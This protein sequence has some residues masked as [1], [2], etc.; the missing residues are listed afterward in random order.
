MKKMKVLLNFIRFPHI[1][2]VAFYR[3]VITQLSGNLHFPTPDTPMD[4][5]TDMVNYLEVCHCAAKE[6]NEATEKALKIANIMTDE[7]FTAIADYV[8]WAARGNEAKIISSGFEPTKRIIRALK[9]ELTAEA[10]PLPG[11]MHLAA[12]AI[13]K[14]GAYIWQ[15]AMHA[16]PLRENDWTTDAIT[17][18]SLHEVKGLTAGANY[19]FRVAAVTPEGTTNF[20]VPI[21]RIA[22]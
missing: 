17:T 11:S 3:N 9:P 20:T 1:K 21:M 10:G 7:I 12:R 15:T 2:K 16:L 13:C 19:Y 4:E 18:R 8:G 5:A 6:S 14:A 22:I